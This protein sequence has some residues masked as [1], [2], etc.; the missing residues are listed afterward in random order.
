[1]TTMDSDVLPQ[2]LETVPWSVLGGALCFALAAGVTTL[3]WSFRL[4]GDAGV[5]R[6]LS[7]Y[8]A[9]ARYAFWTRRWPVCTAGLLCAAAAL[10]LAALILW[11]PG[12]QQAGAGG[13]LLRAGGLL[14]ASILVLH[15]LPVAWAESA[16]DRL[17]ST[18][19]P[20][21]VV[22]TALLYPLAWCVAATEKHVTRLLRTQSP[23]THRPSSEDEII[24]LVDDHDADDL[25]EAEREMIRSVLEFGDTVTREIMTHRVDILAFEQD[26]TIDQCI[27]RSKQAAFSRFPVYAGSLDDVRGM[28]HVKDLLRAASEHNGAQPVSTIGNPITFVPESMPIDDLFRLLRTVRAQL[29]LVVDEYGGTAGL[30]S[31]E[32]I[33]E[34]LVGEIHDE[35]DAAE[36][37]IQPLPDGTFLVDAREPVY[38][39]NDALDIAIPESDDYDSI[40]GFIFQQLGHIPSPGE[41]LNLP[42]LE[43]R[44]QSAV[45]NRI[46]NVRITKKRPPA[47]D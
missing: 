47:D 37:K 32:D 26:T 13:A 27:E 18:F 23:E 5:T 46:I 45:P 1:M 15:V 6:F 10:F 19:L 43:I 3:Y 33:I 2:F 14:I 22:L 34:E 35:Y 44:I 41:V 39:V 36:T 40:G 12:V 16:S 29:A 30:V 42:D 17:T 31:M 8:P 24:S 7:K 21:V 4:T 25:E 28:V 20:L 9:A 11:A 38:E